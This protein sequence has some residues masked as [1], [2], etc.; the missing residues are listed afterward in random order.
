[1]RYRRT[2]ALLLMLLLSSTS[3]RASCT[4]PA[5]EAFKR[6]FIDPQGRVIDRSD[7]RLITTSEGQSY[8]LF[9]AL[10]A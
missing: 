2:A 5:W 1:M 6:N 4:W 7:T 9:F 10:V 3:V 8:A